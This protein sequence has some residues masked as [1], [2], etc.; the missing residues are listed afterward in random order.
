MSVTV[1]AE[2]KSAP[3]SQ[4]A[5]AVSATHFGTKQEIFAVLRMHHYHAALASVGTKVV[6]CKC[7]KLIHAKEARSEFY[8]QTFAM[9]MKKY[10]HSNGTNWAGYLAEHM[11]IGFR[12]IEHNDFF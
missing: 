5:R 4:Y 2:I 12:C 1:L 11:Q 6:C 3:P 8:P 10:R 9:L 7:K